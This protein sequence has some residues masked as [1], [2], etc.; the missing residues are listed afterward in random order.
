MGKNIQ[1]GREHRSMTLFLA[2]SII[3]KCNQTSPLVHVGIQSFRN[4]RSK[5]S[6]ELS[7]G[8]V[9][10][11]GALHEGHL[12]L[13]RE[14][15]SNNDVV[16]VSV[17][18]NPIQFG[19]GDDIHKYPQDLERDTRLLSSLGV[20]HIL[21]PDS[22]TMY[23][24]NHSTFIDTSG[25]DNHI[26]ETIHRPGHFRGVATIITKFFNIVKPTNA[27]FGQKD[28]AQCILIRR[29]TQDLD[30]DVSINVMKTIRE[31]DGLAMSSR[32][33]YLTTEER[34][35]APVVYKSLCAARDKYK[36]VVTAENLYIDTLDLRDVVIEILSMEPLVTEIQYVSVDCK[37]TMRS[38]KEVGFKG[39]IIS[40][41]CKV[42]TVRLID[43]IVLT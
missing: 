31:H 24:K 2:K 23:T 1:E 38:L 34:N 16:V 12:S 27:Y 28:A 39:A 13:I 11:M 17:F 22:H 29:I 10:T 40:T 19:E 41:A 18:V 3:T 33:M 36:A 8:F 9:P 26:P 14:A 42:G 32:N 37:N 15:R 35:V 7:I 21:A 5:L 20:D 30:M 25:F 43:N 4:T 6:P